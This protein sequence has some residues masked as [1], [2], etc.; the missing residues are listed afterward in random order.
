MADVEPHELILDH[1]RFIRKDMNDMKG[2]IRDI[3]NSNISIRSDINSLKGDIIRLERGLASVE[4]DIER[5][6]QRLE[7]RDN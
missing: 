2:D 7:I 3:K 6:N 4:V 1:L 5:I